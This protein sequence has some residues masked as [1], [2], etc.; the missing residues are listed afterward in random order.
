MNGESD[1]GQEA[2]GIYGRG[3]SLEDLGH[4]AGDR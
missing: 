1:I 4:L 2:R 3:P